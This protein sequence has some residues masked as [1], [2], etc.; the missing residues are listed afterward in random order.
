VKIEIAWE[1][2]LAPI[3]IS[4][5]L[6][7]LMAVDED[8]NAIAG[9]D[10]ATGEFEVP[11]N[12]GSQAAELQLQLA[13]PPRSTEKIARLA[14]KLNTVI[15]GR[16]ETFRFENL[17]TAEKVDQR[18]GGALVTLDRVRKNGEIWELYMR[19]Q[20]DET[21]GALES[22]RGWV[23]QNPSYLVDGEGSRIEHVG[24]ET[25]HQTEREIGMAYLF[26]LPEGHEDLSGL[27]W[28]YQSPAAIM[29]L[30]IEYELTDIRLP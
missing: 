24:F 23:L 22:H 1:P 25:T 9:A 18:R 8:G 10:V 16:T 11:A 4:H 20:F 7:S 26:E 29:Q 21:S 19:V 27:A 12:V 5:P 14:G 30:P 6:D 15:P 13:L 3:R 28:E 17:E 2:R